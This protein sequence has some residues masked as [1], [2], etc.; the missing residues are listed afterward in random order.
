MAAVATLVQPASWHWF[1]GD[2]VRSYALTPEG[3]R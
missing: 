3:W 1:V 2:S